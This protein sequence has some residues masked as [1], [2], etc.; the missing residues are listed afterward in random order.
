MIGRGINLRNL[1]RVVGTIG[2]TIDL[3]CTIIIIMQILYNLPPTHR[4]EQ[5]IHRVG[6]V[7]RL[8]NEGQAVIFF[9]S[10]DINDCRLAE[11]LMDV[12]FLFFLTEFL[13]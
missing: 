3:K 7:G 12:R 9:N 11:F 10:G 13:F 1:E 6:R 2:D 8:G 5:Y 4:Y